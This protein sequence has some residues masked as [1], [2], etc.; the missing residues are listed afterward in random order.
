MK[1]PQCLNYKQGNGIN[2][3]IVLDKDV[4]KFFNYKFVSSDDSSLHGGI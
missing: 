3:D 1:Y 4:T 2:Q